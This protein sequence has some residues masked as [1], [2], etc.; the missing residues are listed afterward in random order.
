MSILSDDYYK[1]LLDQSQ[2][3]RVPVV[4]PQV[5]GPLKQLEEITAEPAER[6]LVAP[7]YPNEQGRVSITPNLSQEDQIKKYGGTVGSQQYYDY[8]AKNPDYLKGFGETLGMKFPDDETWDKLDSFQKTS[9]LYP[10]FMIGLG[11]MF[12]RLP[13]AGVQGFGSVGK[14]IA[15]PIV[16]TIEWKG[17]TAESLGVEPVQSIPWIGEIPTIYQME[18]QARDSGMGPIASKVAAFGNYMGSALMTAGIGEAAVS[19]FKPRAQIKGTPIYDTKPIEQVLVKTGPTS[20][21]IMKPGANTV[22]EYYSVP[23]TV[24]KKYGGSSQNVFFKVAPS[25]IDNT[26]IALSLVKIGK[27]KGAIEGAFG[28]ETHLVSQSLQLGDRVAPKMFHGSQVTVDQIAEQ[29]FK[30]GKN[31]VF[32][33]GAFFTDSKKTAATFGDG[34]N[35]I[36]LNPEKFN[37]KP[38]S[39]VAEEQAFITEQSVKNLSEAIQ[40]EGKY[41]GFKLLHPDESVGTTYGITN[42]KKLNV[43]IKG[44]YQN[45]ALSQILDKPLKGFDNKPITN[46]QSTHL[47][48]LMEVNKIEPEMAQAVMRVVTG[49][50]HVG[51]LTQTE[52]VNTSK[53][54]AAFN[55]V[56]RYLGKDSMV[57]VFSQY[58]SPQRWWMRDIE[59]SIG[60]PLYS[61]VYVP[62]ENAFR[63]R[64]VFRDSYQTQAREIFGKYT[65][66][67]NFENRRL[68]KAY[69]EGDTGAIIDNTTLTAQTKSELIKISTDLRP[70]YDKLGQ[71][72]D[73]PTEG[74]LK[75]YQPHIQNLGG[76]YQL[77]KQGAELP[78]ELSFFAEFKRNGSLSTQ[79]DDSLALFDIYVNA[80]SNKMFL[81]PALAEAVPEIAKMPQTLQGSAKSYVTEKLGYAGR[82]DQWLNEIGPSL[83]KKVGIDLP[84][85]V[86]RSMSKY[87]MDTTYAGSLGARPD[88]ILRNLFQYFLM[89][90]PR[91]GSKFSGQAIKKAMT[92]EGIKEVSD[93]GFLVELGVPYGAELLKEAETAG[94]IG[95]LYQ[96]GTQALLKPYGAADTFT[97]SATYW[98]G[99]YVWDD[100]IAKYSEGKYTYD[101]FEAAVDFNALNIADRNIIR[102]LMK[103]KKPEQAF[104]HYIRDV[105]DETD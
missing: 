40:K 41:D 56:G 87:I 79:I 17:P 59:N 28:P 2:Q 25:T 84:N 65:G 12:I 76:V 82:M 74:F 5:G 52:Y 95:S 90:Y 63:L 53:A 48:Q 19:L 85:D 36:T 42:I 39:S 14:T 45:T 104:E 27:G 49:K 83:A 11:S 80:G 51:N 13:R 15:E 9:F 54:L 73:I 26:G 88:A 103:D 55:D 37:L 31:S 23:K 105:I 46:E 3:Q 96:K 44:V 67:G 33:E 101:Q 1:K 97:H 69:M 16:K 71:I 21:K 32:G 98:Q 89:A 10:S 43:E 58:L 68:V 57:N 99:K 50:D 86:A 6:Q 77:Y 72:F 22:G 66:P 102:N 78:Q 34:P 47:S 93:K 64:N 24:A 60:V 81:N 61:K 18:K 94:K 62:M 92:P 35:T 75:D 8:Q 100:A 7:Y 4:V 38:F 20:Y 30:P 91:L 29:G 70:L